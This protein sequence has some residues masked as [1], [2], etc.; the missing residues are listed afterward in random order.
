MNNFINNKC[1]DLSPIETI[2]NIKQFFSS[3]NLIIKEEKLSRSEESGTWSCYVLVFSNSTIILQT[4]GKGA[5]AEYALASGYAEAY[6]RFNNKIVINQN[7]FINNVLL[8]TNFQKNGY[9]ID[10]DEHLI[11]Y[12]EFKNNNS[13][14]YQ[15]FIKVFN[16]DENLQKYIK[17][18]INNKIIEVP[19]KNCFDENDIIYEDCRLWQKIFSSSGMAAG[20]TLEEA[21]VQGISEF[22][23]HYVQEQYLKNPPNKLY[24]I[25]INLLSLNNQNIIKNIK[26][27]G[28][29][30]KI[31]DLSLNYGVP[32]C[33][34]VLYNSISYNYIINFASAPILSIA[35]ERTLTELYQNMNNYNSP[36][37]NPQFP[38]RTTPWEEQMRQLYMMSTTAN[39]FF[40]P[41]LA[42]SEYLTEIGKLYLKEEQNY[43][44]KDFLKL[45]ESICKNKNIQL[46]YHINSKKDNIFAIHIISP[47]FEYR[48]FSYELLKNT[49]T[50]QQKVKCF[51]IAKNHFDF[52]YELLTHKEQNNF[53]KITEK[54]NLLNE[55]NLL[56]KNEKEFLYYILGAN[57]FVP[58]NRV[59]CTKGIYKMLENDLDINSIFIELKNSPF[60]FSAKKYLT[61]YQYKNSKLYT[62]EEIFQIFSKL[63][64]SLT[65]KEI[66]LIE[67]K[68]FLKFKII[69]EPIYN[70]YNSFSY[71]NMLQAYC[72]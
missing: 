65:Q 72:D 27:L 17:L 58:F 49:I 28:K 9:Y 18:S 42:E 24:E 69:I 50:N 2:E 61:L 14:I 5:T 34:A 6:E 62:N 68:E 25:P 10:K 33:M 64:T 7:P 20:N 40:E 26:Q 3:K 63:D 4:A 38:S 8:K 23:E 21:L 16:N 46:Y 71:I 45:Y 44:N 15:N 60:E 56:D 67:D 66:E 19:Y 30:I 55:V 47:F 48:S 12:Q 57:W 70:M 54:L 39:I 51:N 43:N 35:V 11:S 41:E 31:Y 22:F 36:K 37:Q 52:I 1:K 53:N 32:V 29:E 13:L 59:N